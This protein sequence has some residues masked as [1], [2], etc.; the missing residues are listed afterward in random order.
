VT[1]GAAPSGRDV[2][3]P[4]AVDQEVAIEG[5][6][7]TVLTTLVETVSGDLV[8]VSPP[9]IG[10]VEL[11]LGVKQEF[12]LTYR[13]RGVRCE[14]PCMVVRGPSAAE[15]AYVLQML[16][17][18]VRIQR[19]EDVRVP[20]TIEIVL[21]PVAGADEDDPPPILGTTIDVSLGGVQCVCDAE[22]RPDERAAVIMNCGDFGDVGAVIEVVRCGRDAEAHAWRL[23]T[24]IVEIEPEDRRR[25]SGYLLDR[26]RLLRRRETGLE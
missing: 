14:V 24:C 26:Q 15:K 10:G 18:P 1:S 8:A 21:R 2:G 17:S 19:R 25:L 6:F 16:G 5:L 23:G 12:T 4:P 3:P 7:A 13:T 22:L 20:A 11:P 9:R